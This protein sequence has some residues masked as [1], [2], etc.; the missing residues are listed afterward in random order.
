MSIQSRFLKNTKVNQPKIEMQDKKNPPKN[1]KKIE[2]KRD[3]ERGNLF[4]WELG[5]LCI[6]C[7]RIVNL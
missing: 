4:V 2:R 1:E 7:E 6:E 3:R 5:K